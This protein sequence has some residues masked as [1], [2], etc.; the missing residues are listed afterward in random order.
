MK[1]CPLSRNVESCVV[2]AAVFFRSF[3]ACANHCSISL[4]LRADCIKFLVIS[5]VTPV[6]LIL[7]IDIY[8]EKLNKYMIVVKLN[9]FLIKFSVS[10]FQ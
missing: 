6:S 10:V 9:E 1:C 3:G 4:Y 5:R 8:P 2:S 7:H